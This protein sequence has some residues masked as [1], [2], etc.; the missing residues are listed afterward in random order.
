MMAKECSACTGV[1]VCCARLCGRGVVGVGLSVAGHGV[2]NMGWTQCC[3]WCQT[4]W[5][6][7]CCVQFLTQCWLY[8]WSWFWICSCTQYQT[9][10]WTQCT[11]EWCPQCLNLCW[12]SA[13]GGSCLHGHVA[14]GKIRGLLPCPQGTVP[15]LPA[16]PPISMHT[17]LDGGKWMN[18]LMGARMNVVITRKEEMKPHSQPL[19]VC[20]HTCIP[21][22][23]S[24]PPHVAPWLPALQASASCLPP[25]PSSNWCKLGV[26]Q[27]ALQT[28]GKR[29][30]DAGFGREKGLGYEIV[31]PGAFIF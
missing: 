30:A 16:L 14:K 2:G 6:T 15:H 10:W 21:S 25:L 31:S 28:K 5:W 8:C 3:T 23:P 1:L 27:A 9:W 17:V 4:W 29:E 11:W 26:R 12:G 13:D 19:H 22:S 18:H 7:Q 20:P 24:P